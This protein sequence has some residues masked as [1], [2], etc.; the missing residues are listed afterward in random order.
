MR[1]FNQMEKAQRRKQQALERQKA[2]QPK[3]EEKPEP[4]VKTECPEPDVEKEEE[5]PVVEPEPVPPEKVEPET[6]EEETKPVQTHHPA[7]TKPKKG[8]A[9]FY[10]FF[11]LTFHVYIGF[12]IWLFEDGN[13]TCDLTHEN[14][15]KSLLAIV[16]IKIFLTIK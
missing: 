9:I 15:L 1:A 2:H 16:M 14:K 12:V 10:N 3:S 6:V 7:P 8:L 4:E 11:F 13:L 5:K